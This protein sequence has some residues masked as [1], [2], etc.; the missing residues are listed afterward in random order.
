MGKSICPILFENIWSTSSV[1]RMI[2]TN[3]GMSVAWVRCVEYCIYLFLLQ[4]WWLVLSRS[5]DFTGTLCNWLDQIQCRWNKVRGDG[6]FRQAANVINEKN[7]LF[8]CAAG[9]LIACLRQPLE[10]RSSPRYL[11]ALMTWISILLR[12][13]CIE[14][15]S[16]LR[17]IKGMNLDLVRVDV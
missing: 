4:V 12:L 10:D 16:I 2:N 9:V 13:M 3:I 11:H 7:G 5:P 1:I 14:S 8:T 17:L 6:Y 15:K